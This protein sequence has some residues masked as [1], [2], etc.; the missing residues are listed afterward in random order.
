MF[1]RESIFCGVGFLQISMYWV[2][3]NFSIV[4]LNPYNIC[5]IYSQVGTVLLYGVPIVS[6]VIEGNERLCLAQIS[7][8]LLKQFSYNEIH[9][10]RVALGITCVQCTPVQLEILRRAGAMPVSS[11]RCGKCN[12]IFH[13]FNNVI[14]FLY[15]F[16]FL[17]FI[18]LFIYKRPKIYEYNNCRSHRSWRSLSG[19]HN[20]LNVQIRVS[21]S[22]LI[23]IYI[24]NIAT[25][26]FWKFYE[27]IIIR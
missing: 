17:L 13:I 23:L 9:N 8:T 18:Y 16:I 2:Y 20:K 7:N 1:T 4:L 12:N 10:R 26:L 15:L 25:P 24:I 14:H 19:N 27:T 3:F 6:L 11:R 22:V 5:I 21:N